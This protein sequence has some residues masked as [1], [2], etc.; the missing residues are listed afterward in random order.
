MKTKRYPGPRWFNF[1]DQT[2]SPK[3]LVGHVGATFEFGGTFSPAEIARTWWMLWFWS[4]HRWLFLGAFLVAGQKKTSFAWQVSVP[5]FGLIKRPFER[6]SDLQPRDQ[7]VTLNHL[8]QGLTDLKT[9]I[10]P[11]EFWGLHHKSTTLHSVSIIPQKLNVIFFRAL[12]TILFLVPKNLRPHRTWAPNGSLE[13]EMGPF[14]SERK[15]S[16]WLNIIPF[17]QIFPWDFRGVKSTT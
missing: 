11:M 10:L 16:G 6:L 9:F 5:F 13:R 2:W 4:S 3:R 15:V 8:V 1:R 17:G 14:K 12:N 7:K